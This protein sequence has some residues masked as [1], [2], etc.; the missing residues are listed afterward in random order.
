MRKSKAMAPTQA[1]TEADIITSIEAWEQECKEIAE[2]DDTKEEFL[3]QSAKMNALKNIL[4][5][6]VK[7]HVR[8]H[9]HDVKH[10]DD[11]KDAIYKCAIEYEI[12]GKEA[13]LF[14][15]DAQLHAVREDQAEENEGWYYDE[16]VEGWIQEEAETH[17]D[18]ADHVD[19]VTK[20]KGKG[21][22]KARMLSG[23]DKGK[24]KSKGKGSFSG[25]AT[26]KGKGKGN[27]Q[28]PGTAK[29]EWRHSNQWGWY[30]SRPL[31]LYQWAPWSGN[32]SYTEGKECYNCG[33]MGHIKANCWSPGGGA[34]E[35]EGGAEHRKRARTES[36]SIDVDLIRKALEGGSTQ[37]TGLPTRATS[38]KGKGLGK[39]I[40]NLAWEQEE[41]KPLSAAEYNCEVCN[42]FEAFSL[43]VDDDI[44]KRDFCRIEKHAI[45]NSISHTA[46]AEEMKSITSESKGWLPCLSN[47]SKKH[48]IKK[49]EAARRRRQEEDD[50]GVR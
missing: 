50:P 18:H 8:F 2:L 21:K 38:S 14:Q 31:R 11:L 46:A 45:T 24:G 20:G 49:K 40:W 16:E 32:D 43:E 42:S 4:V 28:F 13:A 22:G 44:W 9:C 1:T 48:K 15:H 7:K 47:K 12:D 26:Q 37:T 35:P 36:T 6:D 5:G 29:P 23:G 3:T 19:A 25:K 33:K 41:K 39:G 27:I 34:H 30:L 10:Y 17:E